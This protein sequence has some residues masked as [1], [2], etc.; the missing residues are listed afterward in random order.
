MSPQHTHSP[1]P[2]DVRRSNTVSIVDATGETIAMPNW[3]WRK[4]FTAEEFEANI[5]LFIASPDLLEALRLSIAVEEA[6]RAVCAFRCVADRL[7]PGYEESQAEYMRLRRAMWDAKD[8]F[9]KA[10]A[11]ALA[12]ATP[13]QK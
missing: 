2:F 10:R 6:K 11:A 8:E 4:E 7:K 3:P 9:D 5:A 1:A 12:R 13:P